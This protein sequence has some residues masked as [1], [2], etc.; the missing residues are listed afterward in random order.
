M[1]AKEIKFGDQARAQFL[2][3]ADLLARTV[4]VTMGP[5]GGYAFLERD[6]GTRLTRDGV[7]VARMIELSDRFADMGAQV[8]REVA[9]KTSDETGDGTTTAIVLAHA[10]MRE[11]AKAVAAGLNPMDLRRG[12]CPRLVVQ[13]LS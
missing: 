8:M 2:R 9:V 6:Y 13:R 4:R 10:I 1:P 12:A 11:G 7:S 3:G 5:Q